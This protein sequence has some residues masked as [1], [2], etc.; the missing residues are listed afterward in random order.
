MGKKEISRMN[1]AMANQRI[2]RYQSITEHDG[3]DALSLDLDDDGSCVWYMPSIFG[4]GTDSCDDADA[5]ATLG[6]LERCLSQTTASGLLWLV[7]LRHIPP[8]LCAIHRDVILI[9]PLKSRVPHPARA[10]LIVL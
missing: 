9:P 4:P 6:Q 8:V 3:E 10:V 7:R 2:E 5:D 1:D